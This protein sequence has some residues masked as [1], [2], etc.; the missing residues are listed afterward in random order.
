[1]CTRARS[2]FEIK[3]QYS[4]IKPFE[5]LPNVVHLKCNT[6]DMVCEKWVEQPR[7]PLLLCQQ[8]GDQQD[9]FII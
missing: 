6:L 4:I 7:L 2:L 1:V 9:N 3:Y 5:P 8:K